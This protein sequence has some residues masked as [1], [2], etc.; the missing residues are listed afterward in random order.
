MSE[1]RI[2]LAEPLTDGEIERIEKQFGFEV[3]IDEEPPD[4]DRWTYYFGY[5]SQSYPEGDEGYDPDD[6]IFSPLTVQ[7]ACEWLETQIPRLRGCVTMSPYQWGY[8]Y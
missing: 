2:S 7:Q 1:V 5:D 6:E 3:Y 8:R 4:F